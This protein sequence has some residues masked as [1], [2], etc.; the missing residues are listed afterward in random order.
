ML[1]Q[2]L[3][4]RE[5]VAVWPM[6]PAKPLTVV[7]I[8]PWI[9]TQGERVKPEVLRTQI[10]SLEDRGWEIPSE[11]VDLAA[12]NTDAQNAL[13]CLIGM[14]KTESREDRMRRPM[15]DFLPQ[16]YDD[17][18]VKLEGWFYSIGYRTLPEKKS[19]ATSVAIESN[20]E[21]E[22]FPAPP[23]EVQTVAALAEEPQ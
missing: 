14:I 4:A 17:P 9:F 5:D 7:E 20:I 3:D 18:Q 13:R 23:E 19:E 16:F 6:M 1:D 12:R 8:L 21:A 15:R 22:T 2:L 11:A 10:S